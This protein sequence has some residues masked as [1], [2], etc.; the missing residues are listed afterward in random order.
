MAD[1]KTVWIDE[2]VDRQTLTGRNYFVIAL[3]LLTLV[4]DGFDLQLV[5]VAAPWLTDAWGLKPSQLVAPVQTANLLG[6]MLGAIFLGSI[7]DHIGRKRIIV[8]GVLLFGISTLACLLATTVTQLSILRFLTGVGLGGVL[9]NVIAL[10]AETTPK[11]RR[12]TL[13]SV[14]ILGMSLGSGIPGVIAAFL[15]PTY[16]WQSLFIIGGVVPIAIAV[17]LLI[18]LP[19]SLIFL[20]NRGRDRSQLESRVRELD[21]SIAITPQTQFA[22]SELGPKGKASFIDLFQSGYKL[23]TPLLWIMFAG[24]LLSMHFLNTWISTLL[25][26]GNLSPTQ[27]SLTNTVFHWS[28]AIA[29]VCTALLLGKLG[30]RWVLVL[31]SVG[32]A[33]LVVIATQGF[34]N[35]WLLVAAVC[36]AGFGTIGCQGA[37]NASAGLIYPSHC[38]TT[39]VGAALGFGRIGSLLGPT[40]GTYALSLGW[41]VHQ[42]FYVPLIPLGIAFAATLILL[43]SGVDVRGKEQVH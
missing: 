13:T 39:G 14:V 3:L 8:S 23:T 30:I 12:V 43:M 4:C 5:A 26:L 10:A 6:M 25:K 34:T 16:G 27:F 24:V 7:G 2:L 15:A 20:V 29:A 31:I 18:Y 38:R 9:P 32:M 21:S 11:A 40:L 19:E 1:A 41:P 22:L 33:S 28:G 37:L 35:L 36:M 42:V 17:L